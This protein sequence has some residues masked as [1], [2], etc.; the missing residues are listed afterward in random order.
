MIKYF[1]CF[2]QEKQ[3]V[4]SAVYAFIQKQIKA[5]EKHYRGGQKEMHHTNAVVTQIY[6]QLRQKHV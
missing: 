1:P 2:P 3:H 4:N 6:T 5:T